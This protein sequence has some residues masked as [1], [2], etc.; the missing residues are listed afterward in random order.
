MYTTYDIFED[1]MGLRNLVERFFDENPVRTR[2]ADYPYANLYE[3]NDEITINVLMPGVD[4]NSLNIQLVDHSLLIDGQKKS[5]IKD[6]PYIRKERVFGDFKKSVRLPYRVDHNKVQA[7]VKDGIL[8]IKLAKAEE[9][10]PKK[11]EVK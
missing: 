4:V 7:S 3:N 11:I 10:K 5:D 8:T 6:K 2:R 9:A 1:V